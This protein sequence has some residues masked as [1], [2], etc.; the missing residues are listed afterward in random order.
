MRRSNRT[1]GGWFNNHP[2]SLDGSPTGP[3]GSKRVFLIDLE[4]LTEEPGRAHS[5]EQVPWD[6]DLEKK[7]WF[8]LRRPRR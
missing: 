6:P 5:K 7:L 8:E 2:R 3:I 1:T 4:A